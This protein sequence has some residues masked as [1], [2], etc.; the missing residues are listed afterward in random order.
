MA[1]RGQ[2]AFNALLKSYPDSMKINSISESAEVL[3]VRLIAAS[4]DLGHYYGSSEWV[5]TKLFT[6]RFLAKQVTF[7]DLESRLS[8]LESAGLIRRYQSEGGT[9]LELINV[10][11]STRSDVNPVV[12]FPEPERS[13][14]ESGTNPGLDCTESVPLNKTKQNKTKNGPDEQNE[15]RKSGPKASLTVDILRDDDKLMHH[16]HY[17][18]KVTKSFGLTGSEADK[19]LIFSLAEAALEKPNPVPWFNKVI[20]SETRGVSNDF[21]ER[22]RRRM[23]A[24]LAKTRGAANNGQCAAAV[25]TVLT[26]LPGPQVMEDFDQ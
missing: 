16:L 9:Y 24:Y 13:R 20:D 5:C 12:L 17:L 3:F 25:Q 4:D 2:H 18:A 11:K 19:L 21:D 14:D 1:R 23:N 22:G 8:E 15:K 6:H 10:F 26:G 7:E